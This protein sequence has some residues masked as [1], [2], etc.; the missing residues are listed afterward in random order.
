MYRLLFLPLILFTLITCALGDEVSLSSIDIQS[1]QPN[2]NLISNGSFEEVGAD[3][4]PSGWRWNKGD[5]DAS[6]IVDKTSALDGRISLR[7]T[8]TTPADAGINADLSIS[9]PVDLE[10]GKQYT[11]SAWTKSYNPGF[12]RIFGNENLQYRIIIPATNGKWE[13][14][15]LTFTPTEKERNF[16]ISILSRGETDGIWLDDIRLEQSASASLGNPSL[17]SSKDIRL[18]ADKRDVEIMTEGAFSVPFLVY[19]SRAFSGVV[20]TDM[21]GKHFSKHVDI[22]PGFSKIVING[23]SESAGYG[24]RKLSLRLLESNKLTASAYANVQFFSTPYVKSRLQVLK[25]ELLSFNSKLKQLK[26]CRQ[27]ISYPMVSYTVLQNSI[28][29]AIPD[30]DAGRIK[31]AVSQLSDMDR[32][33]KQLKDGLNQALAGKLV[34]PSVPK[35]T[36]DTRPTIKGSSFI[37]P[38]TTFGNPGIE[39]RPVFFNGYGHFALAQ[40]DIGMFPNMG[41]NIIQME[42]VPM[43]VFKEEGNPK[44]LGLNIAKTLDRAQQAGVALNLLLSPHYIPNWM[45]TKYPELRKK[46]EGFI[47]YCT[48]SPKGMELLKEHIALIVNPIKDKPA[49]HSICLSNEPRNEEEPCEY[50]TSE[51]RIWLKARHG[52]IDVLD[53]RWGTQYAS[54]DDIELPDPFK[55]EHE[56]PTPMW[57]DYIRWNQEFFTSWHKM[58][59]DAVHAIAPNL[60]VHSKVQSTTMWT[61]PEVI[62]GNDPYLYS[63]IMNISGNDGI[64]MYTYGEQRFAGEWLSNALTYDLQRSMKDVPIYNSENH[65]MWEFDEREVPSRHIHTALW[66]QAIHGQSATTLWVWETA[67]A[68]DIEARPF[69]GCIL[70]RPADARAVGIVNCDLNRAAREVTALQEAPFQVEILYSTSAMAY[71]ERRY[72]PCLK[73]LY[74][75]LDFSGVKVG[76]ITERQLENG[77]MPKT[78]VLFVPDVRRL[79]NAAFEALKNYKGKVVMLGDQSL[80]FDEYDKPRVDRLSFTSIPYN[81]TTTMCN[82]WKSVSSE[83]TNLGLRP[84]IEVLDEKGGYVWGVEWRQVDTSDGTLINMCNY[85]NEPVKIKLCSKGKSVKAVDVL[86]SKSVSGVIKLQPLETRLLRVVDK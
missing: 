46:R 19:A 26:A 59:A 42:A 47:Q 30:A 24:T 63:S 6:C 38:T 2:V 43:D 48:H 8:N 67:D 22:N 18:C 82:L 50:A 62:Y 80:G 37:A 52:D 9:K 39:M 5:V 84:R 35:W 69:Y 21:S 66:Q 16:E 41:I 45:F 55:L 65:I 27:D 34:F 71:R 28:N 58:L 3:G 73:D 70:Y 12:T 17:G 33:E 10:P 76:F 32:I 31:R 15:S 23:V 79:S 51:W 86:K 14:V 75:A 74:T 54:F 1:I 72:E 64:N 68:P 83:L 77:I 57:S 49:L 61:T 60:P 40:S 25:Q 81:K 20:K 4:M 53:S 7:I 36:G 85:L 11:L 13:R 44:N 29:Y 78:S 56:I